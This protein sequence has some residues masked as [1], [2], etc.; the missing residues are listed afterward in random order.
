MPFGTKT[1]DYD[2][3]MSIKTG[4]I[5]DACDTSN[6]WYNA[7]VLDVSTQEMEEGHKFKQA[8]IGYRVYNDHGDKFDADGRKFFGWSSQ[9]DEWL[10]VTNPRIRP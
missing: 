6:A 2:W 8:L 4:D 7:T 10:S 3:R 5:I 1:Q 9:Y